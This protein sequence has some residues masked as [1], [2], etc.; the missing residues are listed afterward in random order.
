MRAYALGANERPQ[1]LKCIHEPGGG[2]RGLWKYWVDA[3][4]RPFSY[5][6]PKQRHQLVR[7]PNASYDILRPLESIFLQRTLEGRETCTPN[8]S[9]LPENSAI[10]YDVLLVYPN[11]MMMDIATLN[12]F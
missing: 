2:G 11:V 7:L 9:F 5:L 6:A 10:N 8:F 3:G 12:T 4:I 1:I